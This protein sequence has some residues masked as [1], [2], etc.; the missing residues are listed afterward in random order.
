[1]NDR[2]SLITDSGITPVRLS[3]S[4][5]AAILLSSWL[6]YTGFQV[7]IT[8][9]RLPQPVS[10][11]LEITPGLLSVITLLAAGFTLQDC[12]LKIAPLSRLGLLALAA[13][14]PLLLPV[15]LTGVWAGWNAPGVLVYGPA[16]AISQ[17]LF[18]RCALLPFLLRVLKGRPYLA[19]FLSAL[20]FGLWHTG[21]LALGLPWYNVLPVMFVPFLGGLA[22]GWQ[23]RRDQTILWVVILHILFDQGMSLFTWG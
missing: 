17:E 13:T 3:L 11:I 22:W 7:L 16:T 8:M 21:P 9:G 15:F 14:L 23:A 12:F 18:F 19:I 20:P 5:A 4:R 2:T 10:A 6:A 1:M